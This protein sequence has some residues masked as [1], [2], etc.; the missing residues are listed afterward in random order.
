M[1][2]DHLVDAL[3]L[4]APALDLT[5]GPILVAEDLGPDQ[6]VLGSAPREEF[7]P[8]GFPII[9]HVDHARIPVV[10]VAAE[11]ILH[12]IVRKQINGVAVIDVPAQIHALVDGKVARASV[13]QGHRIDEAHA[14]WS[15]HR[16]IGPEI[17][18]MG[19]RGPIGQPD[20]RLDERRVRM[21]GDPDGP[22]HAGDPLYVAYEHRDAAV[23]VSANTV[24]H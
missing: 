12:R 8:V 5:V 21:Q 23:V 14:F 13:G 4:K 9:R 22:L 16:G 20:L 17:E 15:G 2:L 1:R 24:I 6:P 3:V 7:L 19:H 10:V 18:A 11:E